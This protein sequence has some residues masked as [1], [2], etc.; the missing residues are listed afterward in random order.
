MGIQ[1]PFNLLLAF[2]MSNNNASGSPPPAAK[3]VWPRIEL[4]SDPQV[5]LD[6]AGKS[7]VSVESLMNYCADHVT[8]MQ[9]RRDLGGTDSE[10]EGAS[11]SPCRLHI[12]NGRRANLSL[13]KNGFELVSSPVPTQPIDFKNSNDVIDNYYTVCE[14]LV[15]KTTGAPIVHAFDHNIRVSGSRLHDKEGNTVLQQPLG[16]VH[17]D[18]THVSAPRRL[19]QLGQAPK[20]NDSLQHKLNGQPLLDPQI[21]QDVLEGK[22]RFVF[23]N[24][25]RNIQP[26]TPVQQFP[27]ACVDATTQSL[28]DFLT[29]Q[30]IY[31]D[32]IGENYFAKYRDEHA[33]NYFPSMVH[34]EA[35]LL[36]QWDSAGTLA[37]LKTGLDDFL[38]TFS[39][40]SAF[41]DP[42]SP[43]DAPPRESIE[44]RCVLIWDRAAEEKEARD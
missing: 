42:T 34:D 23:L 35:I 32:R 25:W 7:L 11:W 41:Q 3:S 8:H 13:D 37:Q 17:N 40:H 5:S 21:V 2:T 6:D 26:T 29:F 16:V 19:E 38:S 15:K 30:I 20:A 12:Q 1:H 36:K 4:P 31:K 14:E 43:K 27:L 33:W 24:V 39:L 28:E 10:L 18:Y 22:R 44:V 9:T